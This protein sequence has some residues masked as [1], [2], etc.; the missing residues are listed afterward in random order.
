MAQISLAYFVIF[1]A[2]Y[3]LTIS[4]GDCDTVNGN[5]TGEESQSRELFRVKRYG[6][7]VLK[8]SKVHRR[9]EI[10]KCCGH[11][12]CSVGRKRKSP[13]TTPFKTSVKNPTT[14]KVVTGQLES[15]NEPSTDP[16]TT[17]NTEEPTT[18][19]PATTLSEEI[20]TIID[21]S[22]PTDPV[23]LTTEVQTEIISTSA[24]TTPQTTESTST[25]PETTTSTS[26]TSTTTTTSTTSTTTTTT[27]TTTT[28]CP[29][30]NI[31]N[32]YTTWESAR[33]DCNR[34][35][36]DL[37]VIDSQSKDACFS[38]YLQNQGRAQDTFWIGISS[39]AQSSFTWVNK[40]ALSYIQ[41]ASG[42]PTS[43]TKEFCVSASGGKWKN[44]I[45]TN[46]NFFACE[47]SKTIT[48]SS[49]T[50]PATTSKYI[51]YQVAKTWFA[52]R[53]DCLSQGM[54]LTSAETPE[55][56]FCLRMMI[57]GQ[58]LESH[59]VWM[60]LNCQNETFYDHWANGVNVSY[61]SWKPGEPAQYPTERCAIYW[62]NG[63]YDLP[64]LSETFYVCE[65]STI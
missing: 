19:E 1:I 32:V 37:V 63:W 17:T 26:T 45:C 24:E 60:S 61:R 42:Y 52:A 38:T 29:T 35:G 54:D 13:S 21:T 51:L 36:M 65:G 53:Q 20:S 18:Q 44:Q 2:F 7:L 31:S 12:S 16:G 22:V 59:Y 43:L 57:N 47:E 50:C 5:E 58:G 23:A 34:M 48:T 46:I 6:K 8:F 10:I 27:T 39:I 14:V 56:D 62:L 40:N 9:R 4:V 55:E 41:W 49:K 3:T 28:P 25:T 30:F 64:C 11:N 15:T 33:L